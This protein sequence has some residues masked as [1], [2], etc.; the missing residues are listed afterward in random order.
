MS[1]KI[2]CIYIDGID[3]SGKTSV[4]REVRKYL[5]DKKIDLHEMNGTDDNNL[6]LQNILLEENNNSVVLKEN[7]ILSL[8]QDNIKKGS[9]IFSIADNYRELLRKE[10]DINHRHGSVHFFLLPEN[11]SSVGRFKKVPDTSGI[12]DCYNFFKNINN[13]SISQGLDIKLITFEEDDKIFDIKDRILDVL[14]KNYK[15]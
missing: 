6:K 3:K 11:P 8:L 5:K 14:E 7:S 15:I 2:R 10:Q 12:L 9:S 13:Y 1:R 4:A